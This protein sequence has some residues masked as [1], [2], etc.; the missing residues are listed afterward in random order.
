M[1]NEFVLGREF[2]EGLLAIDEAIVA[3]A[4][5]QPCR[6]CGGPL[7]RSDYARK[8]RGG[9]IADLGRSSYSDSAFAAGGRAAVVV[10]CRHRFDFSAGVRI[11]A[12]R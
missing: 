12:W 5:K 6:F 1:F 3:Q 4:A 2:F 9:L 7:H 11:G 10:P 8:P